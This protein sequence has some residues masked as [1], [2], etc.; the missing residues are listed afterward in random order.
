MSRLLRREV[1]KRKEESV[2]M[3]LCTWAATEIRRHWDTG[4]LEF[5]L[6]LLTQ[7][8]VRLT[9]GKP[10]HP[11]LNSTKWFS[12]K[13]YQYNIRI[14]TFSELSKD[15]QFIQ[16]GRQLS[17]GFR[18][19]LVVMELVSKKRAYL[20]GSSFAWRCGDGV[21]QSPCRSLAGS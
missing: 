14:F 4:N 16:I 8:G 1:E 3:R 20:R 2:E 7:G 5:V 11:P 21:L 12:V 6:L 15:K 10:L 17:Q 18:V 9:L 13:I 19:E